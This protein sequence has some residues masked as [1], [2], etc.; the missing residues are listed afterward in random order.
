MSS[1]LYEVL[2]LD[3]NALPED[4]RKA[5]RKK[6]LETHPDRLPPNVSDVDKERAN[7]RFR[8][9]NNAYEVLNDAQNRKLYD[10]FGV[11][12]P[13]SAQEPQYN[14]A[15]H[16]YQNYDADAF[17]GPSFGRS[18]RGPFVFT[19]PFELFNALFGD[20]HRHFDDDP[21]FSH[22]FPVRSQFADP[23][24]GH[25]PF[26]GSVFDPSTRD[27]FGGM[28]P[29]GSGPLLGRSMFPEITNGGMGNSTSRVYSS[30]TQAAGQ[31]GQWVSQSTMTRNINGR[32][33]TIIKKRDAQV[34]RLSNVLYYQRL[35]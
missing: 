10:Q 29:F 31:N 22:T 2:G 27:P 13:P 28:F 30:V 7:E 9:V 25:S 5:Y 33:E 17:F 16:S 1:N 34:S 24:F 21:F 6:A 20:T 32:T 15:G 11:W 3:R 19:D 26:G 12:P 35:T 4:I 23:F 14:N 8:L 18:R